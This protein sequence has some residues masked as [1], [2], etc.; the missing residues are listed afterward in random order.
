M[1]VIG[2]GMLF[3][4]ILGQLFIEWIERRHPHI[5]TNRTGGPIRAR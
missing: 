3:V 2:G 5:N 4:G 1:M